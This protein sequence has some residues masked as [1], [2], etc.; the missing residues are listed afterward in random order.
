MQLQKWMSDMEYA[1]EHYDIVDKFIKE[2]QEERSG[3]I[4][5]AKKNRT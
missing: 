4:L 5:Y 1:K 3:Y 2:C